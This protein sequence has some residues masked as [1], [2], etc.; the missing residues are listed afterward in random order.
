MIR[1]GFWRWR[2]ALSTDG[3][4]TILSGVEDVDSFLT[5]VTKQES[6]SGFYSHRA[7]RARHGQYQHAVRAPTSGGFVLTTNEH[8]QI[9]LFDGSSTGGGTIDQQSLNALSNSAVCYLRFLRVQ[10]VRRGRSVQPLGVG[11]KIHGGWRQDDSDPASTTHDSR[12][13]R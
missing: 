3:N 10:L 4:G 8:A 12:C 7:G 9:T 13:K 5:G 1:Q 2:A 6:I 11:R